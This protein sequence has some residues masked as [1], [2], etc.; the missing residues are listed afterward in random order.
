MKNEMILT[1]NVNLRVKSDDLT[2]FQMK[3]LAINRVRDSVKEC[4]ELDYNG[5]NTGIKLKKVYP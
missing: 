5:N 4:G 1:V 2:I 3:R